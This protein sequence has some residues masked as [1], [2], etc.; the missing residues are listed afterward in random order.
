MPYNQRLLNQQLRLDRPYR[1]YILEYWL[2]EY[3]KGSVHL[4]AAFITT[5]KYWENHR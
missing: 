2:P 1:V 4:V 3:P 5:M